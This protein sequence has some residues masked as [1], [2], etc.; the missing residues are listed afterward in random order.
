MVTEEVF[1]FAVQDMQLPFFAP[2]ISTNPVML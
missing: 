1:G 2:E